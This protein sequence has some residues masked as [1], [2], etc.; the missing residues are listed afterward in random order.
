ME[1]PAIEGGKPVRK[2]YLPYGFHWVGEDDASF[3]GKSLLSGWITGGPAIEEF[4]NK[5]AKYVGCK[6]VVLV[7][8][9]TA[10]L[11][12]AVKASTAPNKKIITT[13]LTF[14]A[15][16]NSIL[17]NNSKPVFADI[18]GPT[19]NIAPAEV[20]KQISC[21]K[22]DIEAILP[23][24][25]AGQPCKMDEI[26]AIAKEHNLTVIEDAA[27][28][29]GAEY[30]G[31]KI[32]SL[33]SDATCFSFHPVKHITTGEGGA[34]ATNNEEIAHHCRLLRNHGIDK[35]AQQRNSKDTSYAYDMVE[36]GRNFRVT[37]FQ[38]K[39][40]LTQLKQLDS[41]I[42]RRGE[43]ARFYLS[44]LESVKELTL[45]HV[46]VELKHAWHIFVI[47]LNLAKLKVNRDRIF[48]ALRAENIGVNVHYMPVY[49]HTYYK[50]IGYSE[51]DLPVTE[52]VFESIITLPIFPKMTREDEEDVVNAV[53]KVLNYYKK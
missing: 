38:A 11:E 51:K 18:D 48:A 52:N 12:I 8:S 53:K 16:A 44:E 20:I 6:Y 50:K 13:P 3:V 22:A 29:L 45:P 41:F 27:H 49:K 31:K 39:L 7:N 34:V 35:T 21:N 15:S 4:E 24:H 25:F 10:A 37:D 46:E 2:E 14:V 42:K 17:F 32:G 23:V 36:L 33:E 5:L 43:I 26:T 1:K 9:G 40:G 30:K 19:F 28:A 47:K